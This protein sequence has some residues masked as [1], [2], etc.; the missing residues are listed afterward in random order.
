MHDG[1]LVR[2]RVETLL[3]NE[4]ITVINIFLLAQQIACC[5]SASDDRLLCLTVLGYLGE[6]R[7]F[8]SSGVLCIMVKGGAS[9]HPN[10]ME[11]PV[12]RGCPQCP[13]W[14]LAETTVADARATSGRTPLA[15]IIWGKKSIPHPVAITPPTLLTP[16]AHQAKCSQTYLLLVMPSLP[17]TLPLKQDSDIFSGKI[18]KPNCTGILWW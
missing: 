9:R 4:H 2:G 17:H 13:G 8:I 12:N 1:V 6:T 18:S 3:W 14:G 15:N 16:G 7:A 5:K 11:S 10:Y